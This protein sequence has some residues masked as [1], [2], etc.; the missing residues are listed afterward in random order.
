MDERELLKELLRDADAEHN[1]YLREC[2]D[3]E[4]EPG[5][6]YYDFLAD[7]LLANGVTILPCERGQSVWIIR[8]FA[9]GNKRPV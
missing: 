7:F 3:N 2:C 8:D 4:E 1:K 9:G 5:N 6:G